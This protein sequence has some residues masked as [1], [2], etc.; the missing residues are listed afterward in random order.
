MSI[1]INTTL[2][3]GTP[4]PLNLAEIATWEKFENPK[5]AEED[6]LYQIMFLRDNPTNGGK[7]VFWK[8][9]SKCNRDSEYDKLV[10]LYTTAL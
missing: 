8:Y 9:K 10:E 1:F 3:L 2:A 6:G 4:G 7:E 5:Y